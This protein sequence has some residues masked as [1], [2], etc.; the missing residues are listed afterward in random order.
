M[1]TAPALPILILL[2]K[3]DILDDRDDRKDDHVPEGH[4]DIYESRD[5]APWGAVEVYQL[6]AQDSGPMGFWLLCYKT[7]FV[8]LVFYGWD[9]TMEQ[10]AMVAEKLGSISQ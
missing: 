10:M 4:K 5:P 7:H 8:E 6:T 2:C 9:P 3:K 1:I